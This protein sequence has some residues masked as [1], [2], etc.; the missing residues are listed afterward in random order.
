VIAVILLA[1][2]LVRSGCGMT[3][4]LAPWVLLALWAVYVTVFASVVVTDAN[5][6]T[7]Q[8]LL[9]RTLLPWASIA[10]VD[11]RYQLGF[12]LVD[13]RRITCFGGPLTRH[14][15]TA[16]R[17]AGDGN[18]GS[19]AARDADRIRDEWERALAAGATAG[20]VRRGWDIP[21]CAALLILVVW[22]VIAALLA[23]AR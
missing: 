14:P 1:D 7:V 12:T 9:R 22:A 13:G 2:A 3:A 23:Y 20:A 10:A 17:H 6:V 11:L 8:N 5:G 15:V 18:R 4:L 21:T 19:Q 16:N